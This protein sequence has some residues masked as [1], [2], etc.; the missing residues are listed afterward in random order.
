MR[1]RFL[2]PALVLVIGLLGWLAATGTIALVARAG[3]GQ[4]SQVAVSGIRHYVNSAI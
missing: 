2:L 4:C 3:D 1:S